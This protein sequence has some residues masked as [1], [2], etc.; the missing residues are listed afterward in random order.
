MRLTEVFL[1]G[2]KDGLAFPI[3]VPLFGWRLWWTGRFRF[4]QQHGIWCVYGRLR[5]AL[6][7]MPTAVFRYYVRWRLAALKGGGDG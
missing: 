2:V 1:R 7:E 4:L 3:A 5:H 6:G